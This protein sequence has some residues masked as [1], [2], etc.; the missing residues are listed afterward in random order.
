M[1]N[2]VSRTSVSCSSDEVVLVLQKMLDLLYV[3]DERGNFAAT[4]R[5][6]AQKILYSTKKSVYGFLRE[7]VR[8]MEDDESL[9]MLAEID[10]RLTIHD[11]DFTIE[12]DVEPTGSSED[13]YILFVRYGDPSLGFVSFTIS[14]TINP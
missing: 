12:Y 4:T 6:E 13:P 3:P 8:Q 9:A 2:K 14:D 10:H 7:M 5:E 11:H 1:K